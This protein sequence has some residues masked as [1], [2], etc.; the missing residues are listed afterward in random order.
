M[1]DYYVIHVGFDIRHL[2]FSDQME[3][4][5]GRE[6]GTDKRDE[7]SLNKLCGCLATMRLDFGRGS[8]IG[9]RV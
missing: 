3:W 4:R 7:R 2:G 9:L 6:G 8:R 1:K 5:L